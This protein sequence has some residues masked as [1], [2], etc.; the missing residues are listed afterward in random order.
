MAHIRAQT[1]NTIVR[2]RFGPHTH[3][4]VL[5]PTWPAEVKATQAEW[6]KREAEE[7]SEFTAAMG[8]DNPQRHE[9]F[10][11]MFAACREV[12]RGCCVAMNVDWRVGGVIE[13][14]MLVPVGVDPNALC[15]MLPIQVTMLLRA[16]GVLPAVDSRRPDDFFHDLYR[17]LMTKLEGTRFAEPIPDL[18]TVPP[19][20]AP[21]G[22][23]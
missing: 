3:T 9:N 8:Y 15:D 14:R 6:R 12:S 17:Q 23:T 19:L 13:M 11:K 1:A 4:E 7:Y 20:L 5:D 18:P 2:Y 16:R 10:G 21:G 22:T